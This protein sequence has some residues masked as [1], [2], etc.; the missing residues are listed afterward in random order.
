M[1][2]ASVIVIG[3]GI[4]GLASAYQLQCL[5]P[6]RRVVVLEKERTV[7]AHQTGRNSGVIHSGIYYK[8]GSAK[9][10]N[11]RRGKAMLEAF[12]REHRVPFDTCGKVIVATCEAELPGLDRL[13]ERGKANGVACELIGRER[14]AELEPHA[15]GTGW[16]PECPAPGVATGWGP[17]CPAPGVAI[18]VPETGIVDYAEICR[19]LARL[20]SERGGEVRTGVRVVGIESRA[21]GCAVET[22]RGVF[23]GSAVVAC[24][25]LQADRVA[26]MTQNR[27]GAMA[28]RVRSHADTPIMLT[29]AREHGTRHAH[30]PHIVPFRGEYY[31]LTA[32][33]RGLCNGLIYPVPDPRF[34]FLGVHFTRMIGGGVECGPNAVLAFAREG[35][36]WGDV[37]PD[38]LAEMLGSLA[39]WKMIARHWRMGMGEMHRSLST[40]A[41]TRALQRLLPEI[42]AE[43]LVRVPA[44]VRAQSLGRDGSLIDDFVIVRAGRVVHVCN[45]PSPAATGALAIGERVAGM[46]RG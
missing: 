43:H 6:C 17:E 29:L 22:T 45:A 23:H 36:T 12:C 37:E 3:A 1:T 34:P 15:V 42:R 39:F 5:D 46:V 44:G 9:A 21:D 25:G 27:A 8:P 35:Y 32:E 10:A 41:F 7:A 16:G 11:C 33:A 19:V 20:I 30:P 28:S 14:L 24:A 26:R 18:H 38:D 4:V 2:H 13:M 31:E 40:R